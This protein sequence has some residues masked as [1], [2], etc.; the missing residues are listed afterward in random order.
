MNKKY[1]I[2]EKQKWIRWYQNTL[3]RCDRLLLKISS[4]PN[5]AVTQTLNV[6]DIYG[7]LSNVLDNS[8]N[9]SNGMNICSSFSNV[10]DMFSSM[11]NSTGAHFRKYST[12]PQM[13]FVYFW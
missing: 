7:K 4:H 2:G 5:L 8:T 13:I 9:F 1:L 6:L 12:P 3:F 11:A 10:I